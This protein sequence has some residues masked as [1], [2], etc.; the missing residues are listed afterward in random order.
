MGL[1]YLFNMVGPAGLII[2][3]IIALKE[4]IIQKKPGMKEG[5]E[6][7]NSQVG[8]IGVVMLFA[9]ASSILYQLRWIGGLGAD[10]LGY[11]VHL[12]GSVLLLVNGLEYG[13]SQFT[14]WFN[15]IGEKPLAKIARLREKLRIH[16]KKIGLASII[17]GVLWILF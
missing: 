16:S 3:G 6:K 5:I 15:F 2:A 4:V 13:W 14:A 8:M 12:S 17:V 1:M 9:G 10:P 11:L 7:L